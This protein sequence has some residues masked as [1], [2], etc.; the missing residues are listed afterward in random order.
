MKLYIITL[1][2]SLV[3][4]HWEYHPK[5]TLKW[6]FTRREY[7]IMYILQG[8]YPA[9]HNS[10]SSSAS[11]EL[12]NSTYFNYPRWTWQTSFSIKYSK[13]N[14]SENLSELCH[15]A[16]MFS[17]HTHTSSTT[18]EKKELSITPP[19]SDQNVSDVRATIIKHAP[20]SQSSSL[21]A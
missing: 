8:T 5:K 14:Q 18:G 19:T 7:Y 4:K 11:M 1:P 16:L 21:K 3:L 10:I 13:T 20:C 2:R 17:I 6:E 12:D 9:Y 15:F